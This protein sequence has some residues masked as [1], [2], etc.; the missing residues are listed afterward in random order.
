MSPTQRVVEDSYLGKL[1][2]F[3]DLCGEKTKVCHHEA[4]EEASEHMVHFH[5]NPMLTSL[6]GLKVGQC[7]NVI[8]WILPSCAHTYSQNLTNGPLVM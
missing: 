8:W 1:G 4:N 3:L 2:S 5:L 6:K 7:A